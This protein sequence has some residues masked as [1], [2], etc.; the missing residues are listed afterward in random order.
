MVDRTL[1][2]SAVPMAEGLAGWPV[3]T[4]T[5]L[6]IHAVRIPFSGASVKPARALGPAIV[7]MDFAGIWICLTTPFLGAIIGW[8]VFPTL[9]PDEEEAA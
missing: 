3:T 6:V 5:L 4:V 9:S 1:D 7:S 2:G 8:V